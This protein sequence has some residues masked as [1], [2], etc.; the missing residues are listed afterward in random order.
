VPYAPPPGSEA[1]Q[2]AINKRKAEVSKNP[3][4]K[5]VK[6]SPSKT[7]SLKSVAPPPKSGPAAKVGVVNISRLKAKPGLRCTLEIELTLAKP[8]GVSKKFHVLD[9]AP[10]PHAPH[11]TGTTTVHAARVMTHHRILMRP[12]CLGG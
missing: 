1:S 10:L 8:V 9:V 11:I 6:A 5:K 3:A 7:L 2:A 12:L 4:A